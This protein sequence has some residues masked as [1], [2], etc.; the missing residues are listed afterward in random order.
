MIL[1]ARLVLA[2]AAVFYGVQHFLHPLSVPDIPLE[3]L[4]PSMVR[5]PSIWGYLGGAVLLAAGIGLALNKKPRLAATSIGAF[6]TAVVLF[7]Y[8][9]ALINA[10]IASTPEINEALNYFADTLLYAGAALSLAL[11]LPRDAEPTA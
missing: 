7:I 5:F 3:R 11:A 4:T 6:M 2:I 1:F 9:P 8:L 10:I